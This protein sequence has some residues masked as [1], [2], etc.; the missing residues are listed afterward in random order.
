VAFPEKKIKNP[1]HTTL[2]TFGRIHRD[3]PHHLVYPILLYAKRNKLKAEALNDWCGRRY[4][5]SRAKTGARYRIET[6]LHQDGK[7]Y[8]NRVFFERLSDEEMVE[9]KMHFGD[10]VKTKQ[11]RTGLL[12]RPRL[13]AEEKKARD[14]IID[15]FYADIYR[16]RQQAVA[17]RAVQS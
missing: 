3:E 15:Q 14:A 9:L 2:K 6:Y 13:K 12:R 17:E 1:G 16:R 4:L 11:V 5:N 10:F 8:V 7:R